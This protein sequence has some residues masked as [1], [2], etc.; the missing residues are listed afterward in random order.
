MWTII[1]MFILFIII[2][3][4]IEK[5][6]ARRQERK[7]GEML[8]AVSFPNPE[9]ASEYLFYKAV[10]DTPV[11]YLREIYEQLQ[12]KQCLFRP[13]FEAAIQEKLR[14]GM[15]VNPIKFK[16]AHGVCFD[17]IGF[18]IEANYSGGVLVDKIDYCIVQNG[19]VIENS[20]LAGMWD[21]SVDEYFQNNIL[22]IWG[23]E[24]KLLRD[25]LCF[26]KRIGCCREMIKIS[27]IA[28]AK[29]WPMDL[30]KLES[31]FKLKNA[32]EPK[33]FRYAALLYA[34]IDSGMD[35]QPYVS[36]LKSNQ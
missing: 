28:L 34:L 5:W 13:G 19:K 10:A 26:H 33:S 3:G 23:D 8:R 25:M 6:Q 14:R 30:K 11:L 22:V 21:Q 9:T 12:K 15:F 32:E 17:F 18:H 24:E 35:I 4:G 29:K 2:A 1:G 20:T 7:R 36:V 16:E 31:R 27:N